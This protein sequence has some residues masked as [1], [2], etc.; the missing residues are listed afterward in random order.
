MII[1]YLGNSAYSVSDSVYTKNGFVKLEKIYT[2]CNEAQAKQQFRKFKN[3][4]KRI[5]K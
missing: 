5:L 3:E 1:N 4:Q 2:K